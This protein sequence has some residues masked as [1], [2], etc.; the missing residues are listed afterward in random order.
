MVKS[1]IL[2][3]LSRTGTVFLNDIVNPGC[4]EKLPEGNLVDN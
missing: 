2:P 1:S 3:T 4:F